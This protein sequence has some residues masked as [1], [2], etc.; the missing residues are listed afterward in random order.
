[1]RQVSEAIL[2]G[3]TE[4]N[5]ILIPRLFLKNLDGSYSELRGLANEDFVKSVSYGESIDEPV[6]AM[7]LELRAETSANNLHPLMDS[8]VN[9]ERPALTLNRKCR[10]LL[11]V[12]N[13]DS[14]VVLTTFNIFEGYIA[15]LDDAN[16]VS[17][18]LHD[19]LGQAAQIFIEEE[20]EYGT[21]AGTPIQDVMVKILRDNGLNDLANNFQVLGDPS[22]M[23]TPYKQQKEPV[24]SALQTLI[25]LIGW[26]MRLKFDL[27]TDRW[28]LTIYE[29]DRSDNQTPDLIL[30]ADNYKSV[31]KM[32]RNAVG[33]RNVIQV[34]Y[35]KEDKRNTIAV[36]DQNS[37]DQYGR[38]FMELA[39]ASTSVIDTEA[40][41]NR[42]AQAILQDLKDPKLEKSVSTWAMPFLELQDV[43]EFLPNQ[44]HYSS[45]QRLAVVGWEIKL[46]ADGPSQMTLDLRGKP[47][48]GYRQWLALDTRPGLNEPNSTLKPPAPRSITV[49]PL[50]QGFQVGI[51]PVTGATE[52]RVHVSGDPAFTPS[53]NN[54]V[55]RGNST[56]Y[57]VGG[58]EAGEI[59]YVAVT[60]VDSSGNV[61]LTST[62]TWVV[63][64]ASYTDN[65]PPPSPTEFVLSTGLEMDAGIYTSFILA[66]WDRVDTSDLIGYSFRYRRQSSS[67]WINT[68]SSDP[69]QKI[70]NL[71]GGVGYVCQVAAV[72]GSGNTSPY[73]EGP[74]IATEDTSILPPPT[75][76]RADFSTR[77]CHF[78]WDRTSDPLFSHYEVDLYRNGVLT[79]RIQ[80]VQVERYSYTYTQ[81]VQDGA[82]QG[83]VP[84]LSIY[85]RAVDQ[86]GR[87]G[88][89]STGIS[90]YNAAPSTPQIQS[91]SSNLST[92][93]AKRFPT[94][95]D[96]YKESEW[97][98][99]SSDNF[100][101]VL[102][103]KSTGQ[104]DVILPI[105]GNG[106][107]FVRLRDKDLFG[108][109]S[110]W[111]NIVSTDA[112]LISAKQMQ[113]EIFQ[114][115]PSTNG[116][117]TGDL[118][119]LWDGSLETGVSAE[120]AQ[121]ITFE[122][123]NE[124]LFDMVRV[125]VDREVLMYVDLEPGNN[126]G[127]LTGRTEQFLSKPGWN[128]YRLNRRVSSKRMTLYVEGPCLIRELKFSTVVLGDEIIGQNITATNSMQ[129]R[130]ENG[131]VLIDGEGI[132]IGGAPAANQ[133]HV[134]SAANEAQ[135]RAEQ[136]A[137][138]AASDAQQ[139]AINS[140]QQY[141]NQEVAKSNEIANSAVTQL[142]ALANDNIL[143]PSE[144]SAL[145]N[146]W[147]EINQLTVRLSE[148]RGEIKSADYS[149]W[150]DR[151]L[152]RRDQLAAVIE[153]LIAN[154]SV[155]SEV[156]SNLLR[157]R[158]SS[159]SD[160]YQL[161]LTQGLVSVRGQAFDAIPRKF[162]IASRGARAT[163]DGGAH[164]FRDA[165]LI[166][167]K[168]DGTRVEIGSTGRSW[169][170][171]RMHR[172]SGELRDART[173]DVHGDRSQSDAAAF[174]VEECGTDWIVFCWTLDEPCGNVVDH[175]RFKNALVNMGATRHVLDNLKF[176]SSYLLVGIPRLGEGN[177]IEMYKGDQSD[178]ASAYCETVVQTQS[179]NLL[180]VTGDSTPIVRAAAY[181]AVNTL[182]ELAS[183]GVMTPSEKIQLKQRFQEI[184]R[185]TL[186]ANR[187][188]G[189]LGGQYHSAVDS[190]V[191]WFNEL[192]MVV[193]PL[194]ADMNS[195][196]NVDGQHL[197]NLLINWNDNFANVVRSSGARAVDLAYDADSPIRQAAQAANDELGRMSAD[198][199]VTPSEK[200][201]IKNRL[202]E[203]D[204]AT[205]IAVRDRIELGQSVDQ[206][207]VQLD[208]W[209]NRIHEIT[210]PILTDMGSSSTIDAE[211]FRGRLA[212]WNDLYTFMVMRVGVESKQ[213]AINTALEA[214]KEIKR[215]ADAAV[216]SIN[217][218]SNDNVLTPAEKSQL[219]QRFQ[220]IER[221]TN[222]VLRDST[223]LGGGY[224]EAAQYLQASFSSLAE[225]VNPLLTD[226]TVSSPVE[227]Q[228][229]RNLLIVWNDNSA[230]TLRSAASRAVTLAYESDS[231]IRQAAQSA[232]DELNRMADDGVVTVSEKIQLKNRLVEIDTATAIVVRDKDQ[233]G[234]S[235]SWAA[236]RLNEWKD[237]IHQLLDPILGNMS[238]PSAIDPAEL[239]GRLSAWNDLY[240]YFCTRVGMEARAQAI[241]RAL[242]ED[243]PIRQAAAAA[244]AE[245]SKMADDNVITPSEKI[246]LRNR[247]VEIDVATNILV[248]DS[249]VLGGAVAGAAQQ[250][251]S[252]RNELHQ[253]TDPILSSMGESSAV[254]SNVLRARL[255]AWNDYF[256]Y[257]TMKIGEEARGQAFAADGP[258]RDAANSAVNSITEIS[259]DNLITPGEKI[260]LRN[261]YVEIQ[262]FTAISMRD[263]AEL[264]D[265]YAS[266]CDNLQWWYD[267]L[268]EQIEPI[269]A[270]MNSTSAID[271]AELRNR[272]TGWN[273]V[274]ATLVR[275][276]GSSARNLAYN[277]DSPIRQ[278]ADAANEQLANISSDGVITPGEKIQ[279]KNRLAEIDQATAICYRDR[280]ELG[281]A[282]WQV[283]Q[284]L[285]Y[286]RVSLHS[287]LDPYLTNM[288][289]TEG[290]DNGDLRRRLQM[291]NDSYTYFMTRV[292]REARDQATNTALTQ[293]GRTFRVV[294]RGNAT[295]VHVAYAMYD[296]GIYEFMSNG[297]WN[298]R[299]GHNRSYTLWRLRITDGYE[300]ILVFDVYESANEANRLAAVLDGMGSD[301]IFALYGAD[302]PYS[303]LN[304]NL[305]NCL[306]R[307][308]G[309]KI[310][311]DKMKHHGAYILVSVP[312]IG[313]GNGL[314]LMKAD[315]PTADNSFCFTTF[316]VR[317][318]SI[319]LPGGSHISSAADLRYEDGK[320]VQSLQPAQPGADITSDNY[321]KAQH[322][323]NAL[324]G[325]AAGNQVRINSEGV[326][327]Y[328]AAAGG[329]RTQVLN[330]S[331][332]STYDLV[333]TNRI[334]LGDLS[335]K[336]WG[337]GSLPQGTFGLWGDGDGLYL[338]RYPR[339][340]FQRSFEYK[341]F[342][343][344]TTHSP[345][346]NEVITIDKSFPRIDMNIPMLPGRKYFLSAMIGRARLNY[347]YLTTMSDS[348]YPIRTVDLSSAPA[349]LSCRLHYVDGNGTVRTEPNMPLGVDLMA[350]FKQYNAAAGLPDVYL[351]TSITGIALYY[352]ATRIVMESGRTWTRR[353]YWLIG[354]IQLLDVDPNFS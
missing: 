298:R 18:T 78:S 333:G 237:S 119:S 170:F 163:I 243:A 199:I 335:G 219:K 129:V 17:L 246:Q 42:M 87:P 164:A 191:H 259:N 284:D 138:G 19:E 40:E 312:R 200:I 203:I 27:S 124:N 155:N 21:T 282:L 194:L 331:G 212:A 337:T 279:L 182:N 310:A 185:F 214:D 1:M 24:L 274:F 349:E 186:I 215:V 288:G 75:G 118:R 46:E 249:F 193:N 66:R 171:I 264:G 263:R 153:P 162:S 339:I 209:K 96:D 103:Q 221:Y 175:D 158:L 340:A 244:N 354:S 59:Y 317:G 111:S 152:E 140:A 115:R 256:T 247:L 105:A 15:E 197:R 322:N 245:I 344:M 134:T 61:S 6:K 97:Q 198:G 159:W 275:A 351:P 342:D 270:D 157:E 88:P 71:V 330:G 7:Q 213:Q 293:A 204:R 107:N 36:S 48:A 226:L 296:S 102:S 31:T 82:G 122:Y 50:Y 218:L 345:A 8:Y 307:N 101:S 126:A 65:V 188:R 295:P 60:V 76:L 29:P 314:E 318:G 179:G 324:G 99:S 28:R 181:S 350:Y 201:Q 108:Q 253:V 326:S 262:R 73:V 254:D 172:P 167:L 206:A 276:A 211:D 190:M 142:N 195:S 210:D 273:D 104:D 84:T 81:N 5:Y 269:I 154:L 268:N 53:Q 44:V 125:Y 232:N 343:D 278:A 297:T 114:I 223:G 37:I 161:A 231:P 216:A 160:T 301:W 133:T 144:K 225:Y 51:D 229:L 55:V 341:G 109:W 3:L 353:F 25:Q 34:V 240:T 300:E 220:E 174:Y 141:T 258:I 127:S 74:V 303:N 334:H 52:Y 128:V 313:A 22:Y 329:V 95:S 287:L 2:K 261:R 272:L 165:G 139:N 26:D 57:T 338:E 132:T 177:G 86:K 230:N 265:A 150:A 187:D 196:S 32:H 13:P 54:V 62:K 346:L 110:G 228:H 208:L 30:S 348:S 151:V 309:S 12:V 305:R 120:A 283:G 302:E 43:I 173:F 308:G 189:T 45:M 93:T 33:I 136:Y 323:F 233:I 146:R 328:P 192:S 184:E 238:G 207:A 69:Q 248:R 94:T 137:Q 315:A 4:Q 113:G 148:R 131:Y 286:R 135:G 183:D 281:G 89:W 100:S 91:L 9:S 166:E 227:G 205:A 316:T 178:D 41:A 156:D 280:A 292:G 77:D 319:E 311:L 14:G 92:L 260:Q 290:I 23:V 85:V 16:S 47:S 83:A 306:I 80:R 239:R 63:P 176:R 222:V 336:R 352:N 325:Y 39:E 320:S 224:N 68:F 255:I 202:A 64:L 145:L 257:T 242:S 149:W 90:T 217:D 267:R 169:N 332:L 49:I 143:A 72:D 266:V 271:S 38:K 130:S 250:T 168:P 294:S 299:S 117:Y 116:N 236:D 304:E 234:G 98:V 106:A 321:S 285:E 58:L 241:D 20:R 67:T 70:T 235:A 121:H 79:Q 289:A 11:D 252:R 10:V 123:P 291:W 147:R 112:I 180:G 251:Q 277:A 56:L 327:I 35:G 347:E